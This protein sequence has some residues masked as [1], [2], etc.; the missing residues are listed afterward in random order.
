MLKGRFIKTTVLAVTL[1]VGVS[2]L[3]PLIAE[4]R[5]RSGTYTTGSGKSGTFEGSVQ[6]NE[7]GSRTRNQSWTNQDGEA[8]QRSVN[9]QYD[10]ETSTGTRT[11]TNPQGKTRKATRTFGNQ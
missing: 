7:D 1:L 8:K 4:E 6:K 10:K 9:R 5:Q 11:V 3:N 2:A